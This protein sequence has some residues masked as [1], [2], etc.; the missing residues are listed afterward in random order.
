[1]TIDGIEMTQKPAR[2]HG[3]D[4]EVHRRQRGK[5]LATLATLLGFVVLVY[6]VAMI[7]MSGGSFP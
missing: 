1:M 5:N 6:F 3:A 7:R 2:R 4:T